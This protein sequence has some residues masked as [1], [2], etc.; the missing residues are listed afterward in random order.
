MGCK[1]FSNSVDGQWHI[2][3]VNWYEETSVMVG[4]TWSQAYDYDG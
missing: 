2:F 4:S 3:G 1:D